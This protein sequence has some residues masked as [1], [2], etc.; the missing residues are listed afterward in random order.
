VEVNLLEKI[1]SGKVLSGEITSLG[2][3]AARER[4]LRTRLMASSRA[5]LSSTG[6]A[7][8]TLTTSRLLGGVGGMGNMERGGV[9]V[10]SDGASA[11]GAGLVPLAAFL[12]RAMIDMGGEKRRE[13]TC[14]LAIE[15]GKSGPLPVRTSS[16]PVGPLLRG[17]F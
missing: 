4:I 11:A 8:L 15:N 14:D 16:P 1:G 10:E 6:L 2:V 7:L 9:A 17:Y 5:F 3:G 12:P 13:R